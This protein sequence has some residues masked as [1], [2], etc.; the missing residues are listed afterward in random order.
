MSVKQK[1]KRLMVNLRMGLLLI[2]LATCS[3]L[4]NF[5]ITE[6]SESTLSGATIFEQLIGDLGFGEWLNLDLTQ[7][8]KLANQGVGRHSWIQSTC[9]PSPSRLPRAMQTKTSRL[10]KASSFLRMVLAW[11]KR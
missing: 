9:I 4:D 7:N 10:S 5:Q 3:G 6:T 1:S 8:E 2:P 11:R